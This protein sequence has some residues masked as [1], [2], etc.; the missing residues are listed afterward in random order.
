HKGFD[1]AR[2]PLVRARLLRT[3]DHE[4]VL[5]F[6]V[7]HIISDGWSMDILV[8]EIVTLY[9]DF[10]EG[11]ADSLP[12]LYVQYR[13]S[14]PSQT[15][16]LRPRLERLGAYWRSQLGDLPPRID[17][18]ADSL[19]PAVRSGRGGRVHLRLEPTL[20]TGLVE[21]GRTR[22]VTMFMLLASLVNVLIY[23]W[24]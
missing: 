21:F 6:N 24:S 3:G 4:H 16:R 5:Q 7:H 11:R 12:P 22:Q 23:R 14:V 20:H 18:P 13:D 15:A 1:L 10:V 2:A 17:L 9:A 19:R 8:R